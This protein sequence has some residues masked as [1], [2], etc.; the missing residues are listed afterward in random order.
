[1]LIGFSAALL[2]G[3]LL[4]E[5][6]LD[7]KDLMLIEFLDIECGDSWLRGFHEL[8]PILL[9]GRLKELNIVIRDRAWPFLDNTL[10][11]ELCNKEVKK[12]LMYHMYIQLGRQIAWKQPSDSEDE[13][14]EGHMQLPKDVELAYKW[15][16]VAEEYDFGSSFSRHFRWIQGAGVL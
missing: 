13:E 11:S 1:M 9:G 4:D 14:D 3:A 15:S 7:K 8:K 5:Y 16:W 2:H 12:Q 10:H 6:Q